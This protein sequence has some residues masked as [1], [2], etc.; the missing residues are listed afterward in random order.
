VAQVPGKMMTKITVKKALVCCLTLMLCVAYVALNTGGSFRFDERPNFLTYDMLAEA[1]LAGQVHLS[2]PV[3]PERLKCE[4]PADPALP[5]PC[6]FDAVIYDGKYYLYQSPLPAVPHALWRLVTD[7]RL[8]TGSVVVAAAFGTLL[9]VGIILFRIR[10]A[11]FPESPEWILWFTIL[12]FCFS[13][14]QLYMVS[15]PV[16]YNEQIAVGVFF[17]V[18]GSAVFISGL[19]RSVLTARRLFLAGLLFGAALACR[20]PLILYLASFLMC[21]VIWLIWTRQSVAIIFYQAAALCLPT[22]FF[23][24]MLFV[25]NYLRFGDC[26][27]FGLRNVA[28]PS[29]DCYRYA[30]REGFF[31]RL[32]HVSHN[33]FIYLLSWPH[34]QLRGYL[35]ILKFPVETVVF[36]DVLIYKENVNCLFIM[37]PMLTCLFLLPLLRRRLRGRPIL[38][39]VLAGC[40]LSS[41][42]IFGL[43]TMAFC[44]TVRYLYEFCPLLFVLVFAAVASTWDLCSGKGTCKLALALFLIVVAGATCYTGLVLASHGLMHDEVMAGPLRMLIRNAA[45]TSAP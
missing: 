44:S 24:V 38:G 41:L 2:Q 16:I 32:D 1:F 6:L 34:L 28:L 20:P 11:F 23:L 45:G 25:Y 7:R 4:D 18:G 30:C 10:Q 26:F 12:F 9:W 33:L 17:A 14:I 31:F 37:M 27:D 42:M 35:P 8:P 3:D 22:L 43:F 13:G 19:V 5:Y 15:R 21:L 39:L 40:A 36:G 29:A